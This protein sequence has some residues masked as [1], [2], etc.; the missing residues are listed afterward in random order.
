MLKT[1]KIKLYLAM[2][3]LGIGGL[4]AQ[5]LSQRVYGQMKDDAS[6]YPLPG[7]VVILQNADTLYSTV[8]DA[9]GNYNFLSIPPGRYSLKSQMLG[10][11][12]AFVQEVEVTTGR[13]LTVDV[14]LTEGVTKLDEVVVKSQ[15]NAGGVQNKFA[16]VSARGFTVEETQKYPGTFEDPA[17]MASAFSGVAGDPSG[18]ND[19]IVRGNSPRGVLWR[20]EGVEAPNPN[21][22]SG[23]GATGGAISMIASSVLANSDLS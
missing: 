22:F 20:I 18:N 23:N 8:T 13:E 4:E 16:T 7:V 19:I 17:R 6:E 15:K 1:L 11:Q 10:Y 3:V 5:E 21:H 12:D 9:D 2:L 14:F